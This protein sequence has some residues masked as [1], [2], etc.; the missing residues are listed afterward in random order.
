[1]SVSRS[2]L[3]NAVRWSQK[4]RGHYE[5]WYL[6]LFH[7]ETGHAFWIRYT[8]EDLLS[9]PR[10]ACLWFVRFAPSEEGG[11]LTMKREVPW[12]EIQY[13]QSPFHLHL[14]EAE[15]SNE[16]ASG[17]VTGQGGQASWDLAHRDTGPWLK[18]LPEPLYSLGLPRTKVV[19]PYLDVPFEGA[20]EVPGVSYSFNG[21]PGEQSHVWGKKHGHQ[22]CWGHCNVFER[23]DVAFEAIAAKL[24]GASPWLSVF[25][26]KVGEREFLFNDFK[27]IWKRHSSVFFPEWR[28]RA[29]SGSV[30]IEGKWDAPM[31]AWVRAKYRDPDG[32][33]LSCYNTEKGDLS[34]RLEVQGESPRTLEAAGAAALEFGVRQ[35]LDSEWTFP[36]V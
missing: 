8:L 17:S 10:T 31:D 34:L 5:V 9:G 21:D 25:F 16:R 3:L 18:H 11:V 14:A 28:F 22:W 13:L 33:E 35:R 1:M 36:E 19:S 20:I 23:E 4:R 30:S 27:G 12:E 24:F 26:L 7:R 15:L 29:K 6:T 32:E 2:D